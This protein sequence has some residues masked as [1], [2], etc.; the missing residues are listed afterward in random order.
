MGTE[1]TQSYLITNRETMAMFKNRSF[2]F[3]AAFAV[4][5]ATGVLLHATPVVA[6]ET[7]A[8]VEEVIVEAPVV[9]RQV[10]ARG[11]TGYTTEMIQLKRQVSY[12]DL[13]L[14]QESDGKE[15][16]KRIEMTAKAACEALVAAAN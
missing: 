16:E 4:L 5:V 7:E 1:T 15:L 13:E 6:R 3:S 12:A 14:T 10:S 11:P 9:R 8:A 2:V